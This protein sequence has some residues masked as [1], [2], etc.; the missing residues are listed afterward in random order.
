MKKNKNQ[1]KFLPLIKTGIGQD[2]HCFES[3]ITKKPLVLGGIIISGY[4]ALKGN[5]DADVVLHAITNAVSGITGVN[6]IGDIADKM[7]LKQGIKDSSFYLKKALN[8]LKPY[9]LANVSI[10][11]ECK[12][13]KI[14]KY[15]FK[16]KKSISEIC[17]I[18]IENVGITATSG[19]EL[20]PFGKGLGIQTFAIVTAQRI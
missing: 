12:K 8:Y 13:P 16:M 14:S 1:K 20:T 15:I 3:L 11:I 17:S 18:P 19:E 9:R 10:C 5:S 4:P 7:C 6:I 2:S